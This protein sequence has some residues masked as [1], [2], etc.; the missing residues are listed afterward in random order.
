MK[1]LNEEGKEVE[2]I[3]LGT[4]EAGKTKT[5]QYIIY[6]NNRSAEIIDI[7][8]EASD[9][10]VNIINYPRTLEPE[11]Q[12]TFDIVWKPSIDIKQALQT[13]IKVQAKEVYKPK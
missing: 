13:L 12:A 2:K 8:M 1:F 10:E 6:N 11:K 7:Q 4:L 9:K 5:F 3:D